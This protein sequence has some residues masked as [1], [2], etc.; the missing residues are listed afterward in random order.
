MTRLIWFPAICLWG[1]VAI[2][3]AAMAD[4][5]E[6]TIPPEIVQVEAVNIAGDIK[7]VTVGNDT[8]SYR[9]MVSAQPG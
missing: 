4:E 7:H 5:A 3:A 1:F 8:G 6:K 2:S 9:L